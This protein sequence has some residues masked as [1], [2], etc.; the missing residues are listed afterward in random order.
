MLET[1]DAGQICLDVVNEI[2]KMQVV[3]WKRFR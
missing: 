1:R 3:R 2:D